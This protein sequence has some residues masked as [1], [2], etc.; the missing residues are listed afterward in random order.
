MNHIVRAAALVVAMTGCS[1]DLF[2]DDDPPD[3]NDPGGSGGGG[4]SSGGGGGG[5]SGG[6]GGGGT[7]PP[8]TYRGPQTMSDVHVDRTGEQVWIIH[9]AVADT[10]A[11]PKVTTAHFGV[12][13][14]ASNTFSDV[15]DTTGTLGKKILFPAGDRVLLV[16]QRDKT[17][18][19]FVTID[20]VARR[21]VAQ[22][23]YPGDLGNFQLSPTGRA[24]TASGADPQ[25]QVLDTASLVLQTIPSTIGFRD[26]AWA[27]QTDV[28][29]TLQQDVGSTRLERYD[30]RT[31]DLGKPIAAPTVVATVPG[32]GVN[33]TISPDDRFAAIFF[34]DTAGIEQIAILDLTAATPTAITLR[35]DALPVFTRNNRVAVWQFNPDNTHDLRIVD[36]TTGTG[37]PLAKLDYRFPPSSTALRRHDTV[38]TEP[39]P[40]EDSPS[41]IFDLASSTRTT[42]SAPIL[43]SS[44]FERPDHNELWIW[45]EY[46]DT[47]V[48]VDLS[49]GT[50]TDVLANV[51]SVDYRAA[52]DDII[53]GTF[54]HSV[55]LLSMATGQALT[56]PLS[57]PDPNDAPA[58]YK[59]TAD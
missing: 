23:T 2:H 42:L 6:G 1:L 15:L 48:R 51:D 56:A 33:I 59:L 7:K 45:E 13:L 46:D 14:P 57:L 30:L 58:P 31:A 53:V 5:G 40:F 39:F 24:L 35:S 8:P 50:V 49:T 29:Y 37:T 10:R 18:D 19:V 28:L 26:A 17:A 25:V 4:G 44:L 47:L 20:T 55:H 32:T 36:P 12:Y 16:T 43:T 11:N 38:L 22:H 34:R 9:S 41:F 21:P 52:T 54:F 3:H 27:S